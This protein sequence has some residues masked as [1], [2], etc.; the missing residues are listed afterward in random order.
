MSAQPAGRRIAIEA[1]RLGLVL[2]VGDDGRLHQLGFGPDVASETEAAPFP[3]W[4]YPLAYPTFGE[5]PLRE[6]A[7][8]VTHADGATSTRLV[9]SG[10]RQ[11]PEGAGMVHR[12]E[13]V[14]RVAP[15]TVSLVFSTW[16]EH[17]LLEQH[18]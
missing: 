2:G 8:R 16:P 13:L 17:G 15:L 12:I 18:V 10:H 4:L 6:P 11:T 7:L 3:I 9:F 1:G 5:E 14:D